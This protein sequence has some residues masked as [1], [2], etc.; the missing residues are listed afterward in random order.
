MVLII[1][2]ICI[3]SCNE[4]KEANELEIFYTNNYVKGTIYIKITLIDYDI[5]IPIISNKELKEVEFDSSYNNFNIEIINKIDIPNYKD[6]FIKVLRLKIKQNHVNTNYKI[7]SIKFDLLTEDDEIKKVSLPVDLNF[8]KFNDYKTLNTFSTLKRIPGVFGLNVTS[9]NFV[10]NPSIDHLITNIQTSEEFKINHVK[11]AKSITDDFNEVNIQNL[12]DI[13]FNH[14]YIHLDSNYNTY[15]D[16]DIDYNEK[17]YIHIIFTTF[18]T[19]KYR[20][21][22]ILKTI[23]TT[24]NGVSLINDQINDYIDKNFT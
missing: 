11:S 24:M 3:T 14:D 19:I 4:I 6:K 5:E 23:L 8:I 13:D 1:F 2:S 15:I 9:F 22:E 20:N 12:T 16:I 18:M 10:L 17:N 21:D 7:D